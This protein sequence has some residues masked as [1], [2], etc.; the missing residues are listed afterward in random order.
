M[1]LHRS[2]ARLVRRLVAGAVCVRVCISRQPRVQTERGYD[3]KRRSNCG[4]SVRFR[5]VVSTVDVIYSKQIYLTD[6]FVLLARPVPRLITE[7]CFKVLHSVGCK[8]AGAVA[9][10]NPDW[11]NFTAQ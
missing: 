1:R 5:A 10:C 11:V 7:E 6:W 2:P 8:D 9:Y 4:A 3:R